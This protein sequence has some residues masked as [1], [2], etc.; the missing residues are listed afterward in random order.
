MSCI[1]Y[2]NLWNILCFCSVLDSLQMRCESKF[3]DIGVYL[4][5]HGSFC[6]GKMSMLIAWFIAK[7][8]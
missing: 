3:D 4:F 8:S 5:V 7:N 1:P 6:V 2:K